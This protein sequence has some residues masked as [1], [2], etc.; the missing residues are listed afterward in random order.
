MEISKNKI[1]EYL[2]EKI[3]KKVMPEDSIYD[4]ESEESFKGVSEEKVFKKSIKK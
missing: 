3:V 4:E 2:L 1:K